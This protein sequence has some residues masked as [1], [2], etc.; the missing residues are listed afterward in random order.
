[1]RFQILDTVPDPKNPVTGRVVSPADRLSQT[2][3][4][5]QTALFAVD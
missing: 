1:M 2:V 3:Q 5:V 4:T